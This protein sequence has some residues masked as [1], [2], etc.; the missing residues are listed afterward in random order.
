MWLLSKR[1]APY[2]KGIIGPPY[3]LFQVALLKRRAFSRLPAHALSLRAN[4]AFELACQW[5]QPALLA[6]AD[7]EHRQ[8]ENF[9]VSRLL[10]I[11]HL[12]QRSLFFSVLDRPPLPGRD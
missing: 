10:R 6:F 5:I 9:A 8:P 12:T 11:E 2:V 3:V 4:L 1:I 7:V